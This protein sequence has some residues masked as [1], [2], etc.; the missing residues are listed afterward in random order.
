VSAFVIALCLV[1][2][3]RPAVAGDGPPP[4][5]GNGLSLADLGEQALEKLPWDVKIVRANLSAERPVAIAACYLMQEDLL[6]VTREGL[7]YCMSRRDLTPRWVSSLKSQLGAVPSEGP[8][9]YTF[10][11]KATDG[12]YWVQAFRKRSGAEET[13]FP[14]RL[15]FASS[16]GVTNNGSRIWIGSL[17][18]PRNNRTVESLSLVNG[19]RGWGWRTRGL[20]W[21]SPVVDPSG[22]SLVVAGE[23][24]TV[25]SLNAG[26]EAPSEPNW[27]VTLTGAVTATPVVTP[28]HVVV[29]AHDGT[30][31]CIALGSGEILWLNGL[32]SPLRQ[33]PWVLGRMGS[34]TRSSG[35]EGAPEVQVKAYTGI[36]F[37]RNRDTFFAYDLVKGDELFKD[38]AGRRPVCLQG[39]WVTTLDD[40]K[41]LV[42]RDAK[43]D[44]EV[45]GKLDVSMFDLMPANA[46]DGAVFGCTH[47]GG[48]V[49]AIPTP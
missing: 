17:G 7:V 4:C 5:A 26:G 20:L 33:S 10:L 31:R 14:T 12:A 34:V 15:P 45:T 11:M 40:H 29:G 39:H 1:G 25:V 27:T 48:L 2:A 46:T 38:T 22:N 23:D 8:L 18:S 21:A 3:P 36:A 30:L 24:G 44:Y 35:V 32:D 16:S 6:V 43:S 19:R 13:G 41:R 9:H 28:E 42:F 49:V 37:A 47:D